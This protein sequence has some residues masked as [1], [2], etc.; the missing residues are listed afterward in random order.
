VEN[1][2]ITVEKGGPDLGEDRDRWGKNRL[3]SRA[4]ENPIGFPQVIHKP[5]KAEVLIIR[6]IPKFSPFSP[7]PTTKAPRDLFLLD[8]LEDP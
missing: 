8:R 7:W 6:A 1:W 3:W 2:I 4:V 5:S